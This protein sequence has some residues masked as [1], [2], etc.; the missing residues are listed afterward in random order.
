MQ[1]PFD[2]HPKWRRNFEFTAAYTIKE[3]TYT[4]DPIVKYN[5]PILEFI[6]DPIIHKYSNDTH[7]L[8]NNTRVK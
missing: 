6:L 5:E 8:Y 3:P 7:C 1:H 2:P 4:L